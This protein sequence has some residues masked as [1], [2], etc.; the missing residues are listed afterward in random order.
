MLTMM[1][2]LTLLILEVK[3]TMVTYGYMLVNTIETKL[4]SISL[5]NLADMLA[6]VSGWTLLIL[7]VRN[8]GY[9]G[10]IWKYACEHDSE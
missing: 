5:S 3:V 10:H 7:E 4:L 2:G 9:N 8:Q 6:M 1:G